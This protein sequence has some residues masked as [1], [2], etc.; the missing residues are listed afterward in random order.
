MNDISAGRPKSL[1]GSPGA[2][3]RRCARPGDHAAPARVDRLIALHQ[4]L[5]EESVLSRLS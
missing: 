2:M 4:A 1:E 3:N 5:F